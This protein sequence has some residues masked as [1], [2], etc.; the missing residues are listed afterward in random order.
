MMNFFTLWEPDFLYY[1]LW[2]STG[3]FNYR[4]IKDPEIDKLTQQARGTVDPSARAELY[5]QVQQRIFDRTHDVS[6]VPQRLDRGTEIRRRPRHDR[7][8]ERQQPEFSQSVAEHL[9]GEAHRFAAPTVGPRS[10]EGGSMTSFG[11]WLVEIGLGRYDGVF[12]SNEIDFDVIRSLTDADLRELGLALGD[13]K[14]LLQ[15]IA[16]LDLQPGADTRPLRT[17]PEAAVSHGGERRQLTVMFCDLVGSTALSEKLDPEELRA[18]CT[19]IGPFVA[20]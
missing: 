18:C 4:K 3:A 11:Q 10:L 15:A 13:R 8:S 1:S 7:A 17:A 5:K 14:R 19:R 12:A 9:T 2:N 6:C 16:K 20:T